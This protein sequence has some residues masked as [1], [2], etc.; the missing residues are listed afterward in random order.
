LA[1]GQAL[2]YDALLIAVGAQAVPAPFAG[3]D[4][5]VKSILTPDNTLDMIERA[6]SAQVA[7]V[8]GGGI[9]ALEM[10][11]GL[12]HHHV[13]THYLVLKTNLWSALLN[14]EESHL[15][16]TQIKH[17]GVHIHY[18]SEIAEIVGAQGCVTD[19]KT[20]R[21]EMIP[22]QMVGVAIGVRPNLALTRDTPLKVD[23]GI[24]TD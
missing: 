6:K 7:V 5:T 20:N 16:E 1:N 18:G 8:V 22:C 23:R 15:V 3:G 10:A 17:H 4:P 14:E 21:G 24:V 9:T 19:V 11:E 13:E 12:A 2:T